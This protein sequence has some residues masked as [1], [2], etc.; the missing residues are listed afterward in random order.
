MGRVDY[1]GETDRC[2]GFILPLN[3]H[4]LPIIDS[5]I[6]VSFP[7]MENMFRKHAIAKYAYVYMAQPLCISVP[8]MCLACL[9]TDNKFDADNIM[10]WW[11]Y[12]AEECTRQNIA[13]ISFGGDGDSRLMKCMKVSSSLM[14]T[15][16]RL[17]SGNI[18]S[19]SF[20]PTLIP[21]D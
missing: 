16:S 8:P 18:P 6:A 20:S 15:L 17:L 12:I 14:A 4:R 21:K 19:N 7:V 2:V 3:E 11:K 10:A 13:V 1:D 9:G 5:F